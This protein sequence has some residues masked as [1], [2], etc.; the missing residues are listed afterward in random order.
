[1][2]D[3]HLNYHFA[4]TNLLSFQSR[5]EMLADYGLCFVVDL[6]KSC[7][8]FLGDGSELAATALY[9]YTKSPLERTKTT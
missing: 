8:G 4:S 5:E 2:E 3:F 9:G 6:L 7:K 1:M